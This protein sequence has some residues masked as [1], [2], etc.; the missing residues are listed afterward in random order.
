MS[1]TAAAMVA[2]SLLA[3]KGAKQQNR[4]NEAASAKQMAF[5][6]RMSNTSYQRGMTDMQKAGLNPILAGKMGGASTPGGATYQAINTK[7]AALQAATNVQNVMANTAK[8][9]QE[10][11]IL[12]ETN[13]SIVGKNM[14]YFQK[15]FSNVKDLANQSLKNKAAQNNAEKP[16]KPKSKNQFN[17]LTDK[18]KSYR[19][20]QDTKK[21]GS[22]TTY[23]G[24]TFYPDRI[25]RIK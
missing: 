14:T 21:K 3:N 24:K 22:K 15:L 9:K 23:K 6:E 7:A 25:M 16:K 8:T 18:Y 17:T 13:N 2:S 1:W 12:K 4:A 5:Q 19:I 10:T 20:K 11:R